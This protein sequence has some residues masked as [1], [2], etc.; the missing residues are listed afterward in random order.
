MSNELEN[1]LEELEKCF[2]ENGYTKEMIE[3]IKIKNEAVTTS[4]FIDNL[5]EERSCWNC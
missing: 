2:K 3:E 5:Q 1:E 4:D